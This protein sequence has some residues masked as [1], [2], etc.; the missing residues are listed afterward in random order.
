MSSESAADMM[1]A[2]VLS[3]LSEAAELASKLT[4]TQLATVK[5]FQLSHMLSPARI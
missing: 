5:E 4:R 2:A 3:T 1:D